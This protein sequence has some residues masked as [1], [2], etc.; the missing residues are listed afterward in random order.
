MRVV[1]EEKRKLLELRDKN[2]Y[3]RFIY[4]TEKKHFRYDYTI[5]L[6]KNE[7]YLCSNRIMLILRQQAKIN[8]GVE[9]LRPVLSPDVRKKAK[10]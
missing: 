6:L 10:A 9:N 1:S 8:N 7:F 2:M 4:Y 3:K 5:E